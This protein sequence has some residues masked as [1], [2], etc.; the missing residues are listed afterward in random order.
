MFRHTKL[1]GD[2][3]KYFNSGPLSF[4][5]STYINGI[6]ALKSVLKVCYSPFSFASISTIETILST[7][8]LIHIIFLKP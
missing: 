2:P 6:L 8:V 7:L 1:T 4:Y 5:F 3:D